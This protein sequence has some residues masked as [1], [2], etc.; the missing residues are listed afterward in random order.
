[1]KRR[2]V[3]MV[4]LVFCLALPFTGREETP[5]P[6]APPEVNYDYGFGNM[7]QQTMNYLF[8]QG[9]LLIVRQKPDM[10]LINI[11]GGQVVNAPLAKVWEVINDFEHYP[12]FM[13]Q[14]T[15]EKVLDRPSENRVLVEQSIGIK[16]WQLPSVDITYKLMQELEPKSKVRFWHL[17]GS[18]PGTYGGWDLVPAGGQTMIFYTLYSNLTALG[19][20]LGGIFKSQPDFMAGVNA[21]TVIM[22]TKAVKKEAERRA[23]K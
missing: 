12:E 16:I 17:D 22:V 15:E 10:T 6:A 20:G 14:T 4:L 11:T 5:L 2:A 7:N 13:P 8:E 19:W 21:T 23:G 1:M 18:L 9:S 3:I